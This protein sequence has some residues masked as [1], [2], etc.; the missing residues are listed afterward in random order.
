MRKRNVSTEDIL[1]V[2]MWGEVSNLEKG[3]DKDDFKC[4]V[5]GKDLDG[6][7]L[8]V[9]ADVC[10]KVGTIVVVTVF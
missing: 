8:T 3:D 10:Q 5:T 9:V 1:Y 7:R 4:R 2:L 6:D